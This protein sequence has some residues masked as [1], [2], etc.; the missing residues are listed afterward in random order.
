MHHNNRICVFVN[1]CGVCK[2]YR[3]DAAAPPAVPQHAR[4]A[5]N[6]QREKLRRWRCFSQ[7]H[8]T[9]QCKKKNKTTNV[10]IH[11]HLTSHNRSIKSDSK[12]F[13][14]VTKKYK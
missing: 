11:N 2:A 4:R 10:I 8:W 12:D 14:I 6:H 7:P 13:H 1:Q 5:S 3:S 9:K